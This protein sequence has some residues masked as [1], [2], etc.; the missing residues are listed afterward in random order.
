MSCGSKA[1]IRTRM[2]I[3]RWPGRMRLRDSRKG[4]AAA[5]RRGWSARDGCKEDEHRGQK[6]LVI[7]MGM[8]FRSKFRLAESS[9][10]T[11]S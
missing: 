9:M 11:G 5:G 3:P 10:H 7:S 6:L 1:R 8:A 2:A 4:R